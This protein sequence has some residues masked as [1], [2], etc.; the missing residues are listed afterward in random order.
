MKKITP[1]AIILLISLQ[2][3]FAQTLTHS[4]SQ[5]ILNGNSLACNTKDINGDV[6]FVNANTFYRAFDLNDFGIVSDY[7]IT[8]IDYGIESLTDAPTA[9]FPVTVGIYSV[10]GGF[11]AGSLT[12]ITEVTENLQDQVLTIRNVPITTT[13]SANAEFVVAISIPS[14]DPNDGGIGQ[15]KFQ[16][17]SNKGGVNGDGDIDGDGDVDGDDVAIDTEIFSYIKASDCVLPTP[18]SFAN[19][20]RPD[21][22]IVMN[23]NGNGSTASNGDLDLVSFNYY[24]NPVKEKLNM[25]AQEEISSVEVYNILGQQVKTMRPSQLNASLDLTSLSSGTYMVR[26]RVNDKIGSF[27]VVKE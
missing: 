26:A 12:L 1:L 2:S 14:D 22:K 24:P 3:F 17:G 20:G 6:I 5:T 8:S 10:T 9:G 16:I 21:I 7:D 23:V 15:I 11:P 13:I 25:T 18:A 4:T 19:Q 27:K